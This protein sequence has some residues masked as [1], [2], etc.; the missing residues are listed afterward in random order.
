MT[1]EFAFS[2]AGHDK[3]TL[4]LIIR[5]DRENVFLAD[6]VYKTWAA[7]K[8]KNKKHIQTAHSDISQEDMDAL[9]ANPADADTR[10]KRWIKLFCEQKQ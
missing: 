5:E 8:K 4:Y 9:A 2:L 3:G 1:G 7:P 6:G 10:I